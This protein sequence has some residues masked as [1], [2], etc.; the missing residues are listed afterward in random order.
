M[1]PHNRARMINN[2]PIRHQD[3]PTHINVIARRAMLCVQGKLLRLAP[4]VVAEIE[5]TVGTLGVL[6]TVAIATS[7]RAGLPG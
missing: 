6:K 7:A 3:A 5:R 1:M 2:L 4:S